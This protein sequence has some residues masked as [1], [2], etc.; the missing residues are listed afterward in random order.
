MTKRIEVFLFICVIFMSCIK[1][2]E[3]DEK[4]IIN[5]TVQELTSK[6][7]IDGEEADRFYNGKSVEV[8]GILITASRVLIFLGAHPVGDTRMTMIT[9]YLR[10]NM[11]IS[12][13]FSDYVSSYD[14]KPDE[15][16]IIQGDYKAF[17]NWPEFKVIRLKNCNIISRSAQEIGEQSCP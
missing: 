13:E 16:I 10:N 2:E 1:T 17:D 9:D 5:Q 7:L 15:K 3:N 6:F 11:T 12:C 4:T 8:S 14:L